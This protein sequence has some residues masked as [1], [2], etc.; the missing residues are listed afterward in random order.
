MV[1][2]PGKSIHEA[3]FN[4]T[5]HVYSTINQNK[6][7]GMIFLDKA[8]AFNCIDH[9]ILYKKLLC[10]GISDCVVQ[11]FRS[12]LNRS[13]LIRYGETV[14]ENLSL[15]AGIAQ[16][17]IRGPLILIFYINDCVNV[18]NR[19]K[20]SMFADDGV[21]YYTGNNWESVRAII[22]NDL[23]RFFPFAS[24]NHIWRLRPEVSKM[25]N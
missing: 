23:D 11:W 24:S 3:V 6:I 7:M 25:L 1:F 5:R 20:I 19:C 8:K 16:G 18:L 13:Q 17:T 4:I 9:E 14:S 22:Q 10:A 2:L 12:Y 21:L 15:T